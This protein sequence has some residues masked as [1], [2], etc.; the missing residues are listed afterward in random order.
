MSSL[1][2]SFAVVAA[3]MRRLGL[4]QNVLHAT[5]NLGTYD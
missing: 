2:Y 5:I 3:D 4:V 1:I